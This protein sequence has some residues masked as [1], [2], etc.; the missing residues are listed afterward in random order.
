LNPADWHA[1][2]NLGLLFYNTARY[3]EAASAWEEVSKLTPDNIV[4]LSNLAAVYQQ[5]DRNDDAASALQRALEI[6]PDADTYSNLGTLRFFQGH[7]AESVPAFE[8]AVNLGA[9]SH[10]FWGNLGDAY[11]WTPGEVAKAKPTYENAIRLARDELSV[12]PQDLDARTY[13]ALYLAKIGDKK[14]ALAE[15]SQV[16][17]ATKKDAEVLFRS[18][19]VH[20][21]CGERD[22]ALTALSASLKAGYGSGEIKN[23]PELMHLRA[24]PRYHSILGSQAGK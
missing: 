13:L 14:D 23:E 7:Y 20:E 24:D 1:H 8:K 12:H 10:I 19:V 3:A 9:N 18:A 2:M 6:K 5:M 22:L 21:L 17:S 4:V 15:I 16:D 11:R